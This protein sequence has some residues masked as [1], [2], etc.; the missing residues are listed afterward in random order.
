MATGYRTLVQ[1]GAETL[2]LVAATSTPL[3]SLASGATHAIIQVGGAAIRWR[4][5]A[6]DPTNSAGL[7]VAAGDNIEFMD[8]GFTYA[9]ILKSIEFISVGTPTL[10]IAYFQA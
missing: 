6:T 2:T 8:P 9:E 4:A 10:E 1:I 7:S 3:A 5:D